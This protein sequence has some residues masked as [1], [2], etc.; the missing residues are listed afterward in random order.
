MKKIITSYFFILTFIGCVNKKENK[1]DLE[2]EILNDTLVAFPFNMSKDTANVL[3]YSIQNNSNQ[4]Y[5]FRQGIGDNLLLRKVYK[6]GIFVSICDVNNKEVANSDKLPFEHQNKSSCDSCC[7]LIQSI[8]LVKESERLKEF[9]K[10]GYY[11]TRDKRHYFFIHPKE[12]L[13]FKQ[14]LNLT[15]S[16]RYEDTRFN[17]AHLKNNMKYSSKF[18]IPSDS[19]NYKSELPNDILKTIEANNVKVYNGIIESKNKVP[20]KVLE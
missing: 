11:H 19:S 17:Y 18:F 5:Y 16:M 10:G 6:N 9:I 2:L 12:K 8:R 14:Y 7:N 15:D 1:N 3:N 13:F 20:I 4:I